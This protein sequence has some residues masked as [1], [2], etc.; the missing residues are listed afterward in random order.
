MRKRILDEP[1]Y[2]AFASVGQQRH[3]NV[4]TATLLAAYGLE[5]LSLL[6]GPSRRPRYRSG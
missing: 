3:F 2:Y 1:G 4:Q 5:P 6:D